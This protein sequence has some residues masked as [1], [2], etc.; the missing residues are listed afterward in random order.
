ML[1]WPH[2]KDPNSDGTFSMEWADFLDGATIASSSWT[3]PD[4]VTAPTDSHDDFDAFIKIADG[5]DG[6]NY[7]FDCAVIDSNGDEW[8]RSVILEVRER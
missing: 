2:Q 7:Q 4:G 8:E 1:T 3:V 5:T 6:E